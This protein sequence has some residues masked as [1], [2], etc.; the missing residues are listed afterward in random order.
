MARGKS[1]SKTCVLSQDPADFMSY[2]L[3]ASS[4]IKRTLVPVRKA[5]VLAETLPHGANS[6]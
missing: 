4:K 3:R 5:E 2:A 6:L 1:G